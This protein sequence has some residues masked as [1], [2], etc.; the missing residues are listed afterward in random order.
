M[1]SLEAGS[2]AR[3]GILS[4][5]SDA[6]VTVLPVSD[7][8]EG[9]LDA[10]TAALGGTVRTVAAHDALG[11]PIVARYGVASETAIIESAEAAGLTLL[12][13]DE[14]NPLTATTHGVGELIRAAIEGGCRRLI[15]GLGGSAT[16][17]CGMGML[18][19]LGVRIADDSIDTT[20][21]IGNSHDV[22]VIIAS[23]VNNPLYGPQGAAAVFAPQKGATAEQVVVL[24]ERARHFAAICSRTMGRDCS[25]LPGAGAAGGMGYALMQFFGATMRA[26]ADLLLDLLHFDTLVD[27]ATMVVT[28]EGSAD[29]QTL[30]GKLPYSIMRRAARHGVPTALLAGR[31][32]DS[33]A[34]IDA[35]FAVVTS[36]NPP[37]MPLAECLRPETARR[38][39]AATIA[40]L[41]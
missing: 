13:A 2:A 18:E 10:F 39:L 34:L 7:G 5:R 35:G 8:G 37:E 38:N 16:S 9:M 14:R 31:I 28:G 11:R 12:A 33:D 25:S 3:E 23:D 22:E 20:R 36:I 32:N 19:A 40:T 24:D 21:F 15:V 27:G 29:R 1:T 4:S 17:D 41:I 26:G 6:E 30:M